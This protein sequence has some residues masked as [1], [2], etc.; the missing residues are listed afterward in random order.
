MRRE[1]GTGIVRQ[2]QVKH[3][4]S[5]NIEVHNGGD[6]GGAQA[7]GHRG[8]DTQHEIDNMAQKKNDDKEV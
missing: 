3:R 7:E 2:E 5:T 1:L 4:D 8:V 6:E